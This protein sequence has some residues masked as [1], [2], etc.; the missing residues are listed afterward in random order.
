MRAVRLKGLTENRVRRFHH[1]NPIKHP[2]SGDV[3]APP[4][5]CPPYNGLSRI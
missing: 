1:V 2:Y 3:D 5:Y 4:I